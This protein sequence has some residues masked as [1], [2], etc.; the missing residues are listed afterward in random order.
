LNAAIQ[1]EKD[2]ITYAL[3]LREIFTS[4]RC[5]QAGYSNLDE[6]VLTKVQSEELNKAQ[7]DAFN[8]CLAI[9]TK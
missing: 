5:N 1:N 6:C 8:R 3:K 7:E 4:T 2:C 9:L